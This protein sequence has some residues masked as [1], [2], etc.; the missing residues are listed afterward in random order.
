MQ[1]EHGLGVL[2]SR[3][4]LY[5]LRT[6]ALQ[7]EPFFLLDALAGADAAVLIEGVAVVVV[8]FPDTLAGADFV[9]SAEGAAAVL[10]F[11]IPV[12]LA[13]S[14]P[15]ASVEAAVFSVFPVVRDGLLLDEASTSTALRDFL[16]RR[17]VLMS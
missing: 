5:F 4:H 9:L 8:F 15:A 2:Q 3:S 7:V 17:P 13:R 12:L 1:S 14:S 11:F 16:L 10:S 6:Q